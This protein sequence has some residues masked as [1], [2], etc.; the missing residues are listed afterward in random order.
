MPDGA[1]IAAEIPQ[2]RSR[3]DDRDAIRIAESDLKTSRVTAELLKPR[4]TNRDR[5]AR[6]IKLELHKL[7]CITRRRRVEINK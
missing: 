3:I 6:A 7:V 5:P 1:Q 4:V 2:P